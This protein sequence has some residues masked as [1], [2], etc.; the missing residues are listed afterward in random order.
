MKR[1]LFI[2]LLLQV[3]TS[4]GMAYAQTTDV[5][6][7]PYAAFWKHRASVIEYKGSPLSSY[8]DGIVP[9]I[10]TNYYT[11]S[12][13][14]IKLASK[15]YTSYVNATD[16]AMLL[17]LNTFISTTAPGLYA[18]I[19]NLSDYIPK[20]VVTAAGDLIIATGNAAVTRLGIG[21]NGTVLTSNGTTASWV[22]PSSGIPVFTPLSMANG[23]YTG[24]VMLDTMTASATVGECLYRKSDGWAIAKADS[25]TTLPALGLCV[26]T[27]TGSRKVLTHGIVRNTS[28]SFTAGQK[29][30]VS[31]GTAGAI[32]STAP[33]TATNHIQVIGVALSATV[34]YFFFDST[35]VEI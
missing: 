8:L 14:D 10:E 1:L 11:T 24:E 3:L 28:W 19:A 13:V 12:E 2:S 30:Y 7:H 34:V 22:A 6:I 18:T 35:Y 31:A 9:F 29:I 17:A 23:D 33:S 20:S 5:E 4:V 32:T 16:E 21:V 27:G 15:A 25:A 26:E